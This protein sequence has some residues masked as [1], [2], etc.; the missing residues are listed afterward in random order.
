VVVHG[1]R[2]E[3]RLGPRRHD[4][5]WHAESQARVVV[6]VRRLSHRHLRVAPVAGVERSRGRHVIVIAAVLVV[7]EDQQRACPRVRPEQRL[8]DLADEVL[9]RLHVLRVLLTGVLIV[10]L[11]H[12]H[13]RQRARLTRRAERRCGHARRPERTEEV[14]ALLCRNVRGSEQTR[15]GQLRVVVGPGDAVRV[16]HLEDVAV[17]RCHRRGR[18]VGADEARGG[19]RHHEDAVRIRLAQ[20]RA[21]IPIAYRERRCERVV[22]RQQRL[23]PIAE[24]LLAAAPKESVHR[25]GVV[26]E[27]AR[28]PGLGN[29]K[30]LAAVGHRERAIRSS[31]RV[32]L[33]HRGHAIARQRRPAVH[34]AAA[35][36]DVMRQHAEVVVERMVLH[37]H[38]DDVIDVGKFGSEVRLR[39]ARGTRGKRQ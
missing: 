25:P 18:R 20:R 35:R 34:L 27:V 19:R 8:D 31:A 29:A 13:R 10:G 12:D 15:R 30:R 33:G 1:V 37:H 28:V 23:V 21:E 32:G 14:R 2:H 38:D 4:H 9:P 16:E 7:R 3:I 24:R 17:V 39:H 6:T 5:R 11:D 22:E 26:R 36:R